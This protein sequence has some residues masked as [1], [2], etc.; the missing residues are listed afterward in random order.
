MKKF[1]TLLMVLCLM[2]TACGQSEETKPMDLP[3]NE[4]TVTV[5]KDGCEYILY[6]HGGTQG[7]TPQIDNAICAINEYDFLDGGRYRALEENDIDLSVKQ[8][9]KQDNDNLIVTLEFTNKNGKKLTRQNNVPMHYSLFTTKENDVDVIANLHLMGG[10]ISVYKD[11]FILSGLT[12]TEFYS[13]DNFKKLDKTLDY[14]FLQDSE[15]YIVDVAGTKDGYTAM[16]VSEKG[17]G[18][19]KFDSKGGFEKDYRLH[20]DPEH[21]AHYIECF[22]SECKYNK[23]NMDILFPW[24]RYHIEQAGQYILVYDSYFRNYP[25]ENTLLT[26]IGYIY[27]TETDMFYNGGGNVDNAQGENR[28]RLFV[29]GETLPDFYNIKGDIHPWFAILGEGDNARAFSFTTDKVNSQFAYGES[30]ISGD[31]ITTIFNGENVAVFNPNCNAWGYFDFEKGTVDFEY[32]QFD[33][34]D[35]RKVTEKDGY[36]IYATSSYGGGDVSYSMMILKEETT[37]KTKYLD[38]IGGMYGGNN[39]V[40]FFANGDVYVIDRDGFAIFDRNMDN[41]DYTIRLGDNFPFG[42]EIS[43]TMSR[44]LLAARRV[45][46]DDLRHKYVV[47]YFELENDMPSRYYYLDLDKNDFQLKATYKVALLDKEGKLVKTIDTGEHA[48]TN[49]FGYADV[50]MYMPDENT[51][52]FFTWKKSEDNVY[53][54]G[55][56][57]LSTEKYTSI[58]N[59]FED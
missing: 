5:E 33:L 6:G 39:G 54:K 30:E 49:V 15:Y 37:G 59:V 4:D 20:S 42:E 23:Q 53:T 28:F 57:N 27:D 58:V 35:A 41:P 14:S 29:G 2:F 18:F 9:Y 43:D 48:V 26:D 45:P 56:L 21:K 10:D 36:G 40:G 16:Y 47:I 50:N 51:V 12:Q 24:Y 38:T 8:V 3:V 44:F 22:G 52:E 55:R 32:L 7:F 13:L 25:Q 17:N 1:L 19:A 11:E 34:T 31:G 46:G